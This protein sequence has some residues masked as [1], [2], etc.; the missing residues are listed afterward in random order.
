MSKSIK[1]KE[2]VLD[3]RQEQLARIYGRA[4]VAAADATGKG[5]ELVEEL[6]SLVADV[7]NRN[8]EFEKALTGDALSEDETTELIDRVF[9]GR[10]SNEVINLLKVMAHHRRLGALRM[11][12]HTVHQLWGESKGRR[13][14]VVRSATE[15]PASLKTELAAAL[16]AKL[17]IEAEMTVMV[18][19]ELI[20]GM[21]VQVGD[22]IFDG[23]VRTSLER[24]RRQMVERAIDAIESRPEKFLLEIAP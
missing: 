15:L 12:V 14:V 7:L 1:A 11:V 6:D 19:P 23:S 5:A 10:A 16:K 2:T 21:V 8:P 9:K 17:G 3:V 24:T 22:T 18:D 13:A 4:F 20:A